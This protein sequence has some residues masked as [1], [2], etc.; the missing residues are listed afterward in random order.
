MHTM[1]GM[2]ERT[3][4]TVSAAFRERFEVLEVIG[5]G[6]FGLVLLAK[7]K[8]LNRLV[9]VKYLN[10]TKRLQEELEKRFLREAKVLSELDHPNI[11]SIFEY[12]VDGEIPYLVQEYLSGKSLDELLERGGNLPWRQVVAYSRQIASG[13][14]YAHENGVIHRDLK[15]ANLFVTEDSLVEILDFGLAK[16]PGKHTTLTRTGSVVGTPVYMPPEMLRGQKA[17]PAGDVYSLGSTMYEMLSNALPYQT[18]SA[19]FFKDKMSLPP[20]PL[21]KMTSAFIPRRLESLVESMLDLEPQERPTAKEVVEYLEEMA[22]M[23]E[24]D[25]A[26]EISSRSKPLTE[27]ATECGTDTDAQPAPEITRP[28]EGVGKRTFQSVVALAVIFVG[29]WILLTSQSAPKV[30]VLSFSIREGIDSAH[31][32]WQTDRKVATGVEQGPVGNDVTTIWNDDQKSTTRHEILL[33]GLRP[34]Q[35]YAVTLL[36]GNERRGPTKIFSTLPTLKISRFSSTDICPTALTLLL[37]ATQ[38]AKLIFEVREQGDSEVLMTYSPKGEGPKWTYRATCLP[39][40]SSL[41]IKAKVTKGKTHLK[42]QSIDVSTPPA[43]VHIIFSGG[44][45]REKS[46]GEVDIESLMHSKTKARGPLKLY[47]G[48]LVISHDKR[49]LFRLNPKL[50]KLVWSHNYD[51]YVDGIRIYDNRVF[52]V[53]KQKQVHCCSFE[54]GRRL[55]FR[56]FPQALEPHFFADSYGVVVWRKELGPVRLEPRTGE[57]LRPIDNA[58][59]KPRWAISAEGKLFAFSELFDLWCYDLLTGK[60]R[61]DLRLV[62]P[63]NM[64]AQPLTIGK[65][66]FAGL[67]DG[68]II[69]GPPGK[70]RRLHIMTGERQIHY[71]AHDEGIVYA[72]T[73]DPLGIHAAS[74]ETGKRLWTFRPPS[75]PKTPLIAR[76]GYIYYADRRDYL[77]CLNGKTGR[78]LYQ[79]YGN[80]M[81]HFSIIATEDGAI[82]SSSLLDIS[83]VKDR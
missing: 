14:A 67:V 9:A 51:W 44:V 71:M 50:G 30:K 20:R 36:F 76:D 66:V 56:R 60:R 5:R 53:D 63:Q 80:V 74:L 45:Q 22:A 13:L 41:T 42:E 21:E 75:R 78:L 49:A 62:I 33:S 25:L 81:M 17:G 73:F 7:Q 3:G 77:V 52:L 72:A 23:S 54:N 8:T 11:V 37:T 19:S 12:G 15:P 28:L 34:Q 31:L 32:T 46:N 48:D 24:E 39:A 69:G 16:A 70:N 82:F 35:R 1:P 55:W 27:S 79:V 68:S 6:A 58:V 57:T 10:S 43:K 59:L 47:K 29:A 64:R 2:T 83:H 40:A 65:E 18:Q 38:K 61:N 4:V 26:K